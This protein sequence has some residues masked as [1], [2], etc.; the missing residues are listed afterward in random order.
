V[1]HINRRT[2]LKSTLAGTALTVA[3]AAGLLKPAR[4]LAAEWPKAA[5][6]AEKIEA[7]LQALYGSGQAAPSGS[8]K[9]KAQLQAETG[10][11]VPISVTADLPNVEAIS[12]YVEKNARPLVANVSLSGAEPYFNTRMK[13]GQTSDVHVVCKSAGKLYSAKQT[14][15]VTVGGCGG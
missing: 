7:A 1:T 2:F 3:A 14:I 15:K 4:V 5:F 13:M 9:I 11:Q 6:D 12:I 8:I 10:D